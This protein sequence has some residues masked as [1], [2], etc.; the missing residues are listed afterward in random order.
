MDLILCF[1]SGVLRDTEG[2]GK[3]GGQLRDQS[4]AWLGCNAR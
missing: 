1:V 2:I 3:G 4:T